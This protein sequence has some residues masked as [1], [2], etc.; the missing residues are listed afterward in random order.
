MS[1]EDDWASFLRVDQRRFYWVRSILGWGLI[2]QVPNCAYLIVASSY[3]M[4][5][6]QQH[7]TIVADSGRC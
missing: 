4:Y 3:A 5:C 2:G 7:L 6:I 1:E